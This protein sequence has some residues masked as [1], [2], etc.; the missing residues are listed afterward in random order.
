MCNESSAYGI[1]TKQKNGEENSHKLIT[2]L[3]VYSY[4]MKLYK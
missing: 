4:C 1:L 2:A 3:P